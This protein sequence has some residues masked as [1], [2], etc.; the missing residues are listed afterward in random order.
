[1]GNAVSIKQSATAGAMTQDIQQYASITES[2]LSKYQPEMS[3]VTGCLYIMLNVIGQE[4]GFRNEFT[5]SNLTGIDAIFN[6]TDAINFTPTPPTERYVR[7]YLHYPDVASILQNPVNQNPVRTQQYINVMQ[8]RCALGCSAVMGYNFVAST[9]P[10]SAFQH[11]IMSNPIAKKMV[12]DLGIWV[13]PGGSLTGLFTNDTTGITRAIA[14]GI[15]LLNSKY[16]AAVRRHSPGTAMYIAVGSYVGD[17]RFMDANGYS[18]ITRQQQ[19]YSSQSRISI[20]VSSATNLAP[21]NTSGQLLAY[22]PPN[23]SHTAPVTATAQ[24][25]TGI[26]S[27]APP[28]NMSSPG[29]TPA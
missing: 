19:V 24:T 15:I 7:D 4:S 11:D 16:T 27:N 12:N 8:G 5:K 20:L 10:R 13:T 29:C 9:Y 14:A 21:V 3:K 18:P 26:S 25:S 17:A 28:P 1:M 22:S 6:G 23:Q 2:L